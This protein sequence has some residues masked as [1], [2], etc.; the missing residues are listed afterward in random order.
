[1][2]IEINLSKDSP[3]PVYR[4][5]VQQITSLIKQGQLKPGDKLPTER[6]LASRF[7]IAR[8][9]VKKAYELMTKEGLIETTHGR[10]TFI[11]SRQDIIPAG[12][13]ERAIKLIDDLLDEL[14]AM[15]FSYQE[16][17]T[18]IDLAIIKREEKLENLNVAVVDC[19]PESLSIFER[20][21]TFLQHVRVV[22]F[23]L[24]E[25]VA[26]PEPE[27]R[28]RPF[29]L[30]LTTNTHY[31]ELMGKVPNLRE[32][33]IQVAVSPSQEVIIEMASL[34]P[35]QRLGVVCESPNFLARVVARI[36]EMGLAAGS[37]PH[38]FLKEE[39]QLPKFLTKIDVVFVPPG[40][41]LHRKKEN[42]AAVQEFTQRGGKVIV[43]DYQIE[44][45]SLLYVEER[46]RQILNP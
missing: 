34:S 9:T 33:L 16:I 15:N 42:L 17:K 27:N 40:Y 39:S 24:D 10:G 7:S 4:Q 5:I 29:D 30:I 14:K 18:F 3:V 25:I 12:R 20:Q 2:D 35:L 36:K 37:I 11:S 23:L 28:L 22:K 31:S 41:H 38:L 19:N 1:M 13:K 21:L 26:D 8:G 45:G 32:K 46:I 44:R 6:E 43:F